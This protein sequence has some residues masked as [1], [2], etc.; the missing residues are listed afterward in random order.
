MIKIQNNQYKVIDAHLHLPWQDE[1]STTEKKLER[2][3]KEMRNNGIDYGILIA[4][5][6]LESNIG[7]NEECLCAV[8]NVNNLFL[9]FGISPIERLGEQLLYCEK[10]LKDNKVVGIKLFPGHEDFCMNDPR[11]KDVINLCLKYEVPLL[12][13]TEW[14]SE[15]YPQYSHPFFIKQLAQ[16]NSDLNIICCH[17]WNPRVI[18]S[19]KLTQE[20]SNIFYDISSF[21]MGKQFFREHPKTLFP[22]KEKATEYLRYLMKICSERVLFGSDYG[23]LSIAEHLELVLEAGL[24]GDELRTI[25]YKN[26]NN[27]FKLGFP[28]C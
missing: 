17:V 24:K 3:Q 2:L 7:N 19:L 4:D 8:S 12:I 25:L 13:H 22:S 5:S 6:I 27:I 26:V 18:E 23:S 10:L 14:N 21:C 16:S 9:V 20:F 15:E 1:F 28:N 11:I